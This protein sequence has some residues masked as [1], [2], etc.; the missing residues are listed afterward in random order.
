MKRAF[1]V[2]VFAG[3]ASLAFAGCG[4]SASEESDV[5]G[6]DG[7]VVSAGTY[8]LLGGTA[9]FD[10]TNALNVGAANAA[11]IGGG[12]LAYFDGSGLQVVVVP[13]PALRGFVVGVLGTAAGIACARG[14]RRGGPGVGRDSDA[15]SWK[16]R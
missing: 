12:S 13:E 9:T 2:L 11:A 14:R 7:T 16:A 5:L 3:L 10:L 8:S 4:S 15:A 6:P 1:L